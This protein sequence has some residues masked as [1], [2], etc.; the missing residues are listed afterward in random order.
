MQ[1]SHHPPVTSLYATNDVKKVEMLWWH[2]PVPRFYG[3][4]RF[5]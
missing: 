5:L 4:P 3:E 2:Q 1:V